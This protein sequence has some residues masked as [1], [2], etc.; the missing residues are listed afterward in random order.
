MPIK[1][2]GSKTRKARGEKL[3]SYDDYRKE[4]G[5]VTEQ[6]RDNLASDPKVFGVNLAR[7]ALKKFRED[8]EKR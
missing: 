3:Y 7:E 8:L 2:K 6:E 1:K 4:F 5:V